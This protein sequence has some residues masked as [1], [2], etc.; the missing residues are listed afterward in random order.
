MN[1]AGWLVCVA[2]LGCLPGR[3]A[4]QTPQIETI[5][6]VIVTGDVDG[7]F[8]NPVCGG[9]ETLV[10]SDDGAFSYALMRHASDPDHPLVIDTGGLLT[11][12]GVA[13]FSA[14]RDPAALARLAHDL[15][16]RALALGL[17]DLAA[18]RPQTIAVAREL[19]QLGIP[20]LAS[21][22]RCTEEASAFC[23]QLVDASDGVST[24]YVNGRLTAVMSVLRQSAT[25]AI[26]PE[27]A[28]GIVIED[29]I[30]T[31]ERFTRMA[32][33]AGAEIVVAVVDDHVEGGALNL[34]TELAADARPD[35]LLVSGQ[36]ELLFARPQTVRPV[37]VGPP[38]RDGVEVRIRESAEIRDGYEFLA[39]PLEGRGVSVAE[40]VLDWI[41]AIGDEYCDAWGAPLD[42]AELDEPIDVDGM[43]NLV[44]RILR[45]TSGADVAVLNRQALDTRWTPA[46]PGSLSASDIYVALEY[47]EPLQ[48][49]EVDEAWLKRLAESAELTGAIVTPGLTTSGTG[50]DRT[51]QV[52]GHSTDAHA[53]YRVVTIRF[54]AAGGDDALVPGL[55][56][57][58]AWET[59]GERSLRTAALRYLEGARDQDPRQSLP[60]DEGTLEWQFIAAADLTFSGSSIGNP[61]QRCTDEMRTT[62]PDSCDAQGFVLVDGERVPAYASTQLSLADV[63]TFGFNITLAANAAAPDWTWQNTSNLLYR[64]T[65]TEP[66]GSTG[67]AFVEAAD[68]IRAR[69]TL[70]WRGLR[71]QQDNGWYVPDPTADV[72]VESE[73]TEPVGRGYHWFLLRPTLGFRFQ[74]A[75]KLQFQLSGGFQT[76][77]FEPQ[78]TVEAGLGATLTLSPWDFMRLDSRY[79][80]L[81][82]TF[83]YFVTLTDEY[84]RGTLRGTLG[85]SFDLAGPLA[86]VFQGNLFLQHQ[87]AQDVGAAVS[88]TAGIRLGYLGRAV[89]P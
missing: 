26:S 41:D 21:N 14:E 45:E 6:R 38:E 25:N 75:D 9:G 87:S 52:G 51:V 63:L 27:R 55:G 72:F 82:F 81:G 28:R 71:M 18:S 20:M 59:L 40:P 85:A 53:R 78:P 8:A 66:T 83:D 10:P 19:R 5:A 86:I 23:D 79:A 7:R 37:L 34:A 11:P 43:L 57:L 70:S 22:L 61:M 76:Q 65:W 73:F 30:A 56:N 44:A 36:D 62:D 50:A 68:Q 15:G 54:L 12:H 74:L 33:E 13:R 48:A 24:H 32:H 39:Q 58:G 42:G 89:G 69:S 77:V 64:S 49:A 46:Q 31:I 67:S 47:D 88:V 3:G 17:N 80:R 2:A 4:A 16:Y 35:L 84:A 60:D 29:P 1:R